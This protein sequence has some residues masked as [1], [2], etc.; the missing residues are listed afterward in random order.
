MR[1]LLLGWVLV[2]APVVASAEPPIPN[3]VVPD[4]IRVGGA[5]NASGAPDPSLP[6]TVIVRDFANNP[7]PNSAVTLDFYDCWDL[8]LC[9]AVVAGTVLSCTNRSVSAVTDVDGNVTFSILGGGIN[10]GAT[11]PPNIAGG[12]GSDCLLVYADGVLLGRSTAVVYDAN[13][14]LPGG[15]GVNGLDVAITINDIGA[16]GLGAPYRG[17][18]DYNQNGVLNG[19]DLA[20]LKSIVGAS[21]LGQGSGAG[22]ASGGAPMP[23]CP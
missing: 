14:S 2:A 1:V 4:Y 11:S 20:S 23:F 6:F 22:C 17:R 12:P 3:S 8:R 5:Q 18:S 19:A 10:P 7:V 13:G 9:T 21:A 15:G 16:A